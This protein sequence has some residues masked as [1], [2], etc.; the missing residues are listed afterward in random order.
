MTATKAPSKH[1]R[2]GITLIEAVQQYGDDE[3]AEQWLVCRRWPDG[4]RCPDCD[5]KNVAK[6]APRA[7]RRTPEYHCN[8]CKLDFTVKTGTVMH[9]S[10]LSLN[11]WAIAFFLFSTNLKG[12]SSMKLHRD[13]G[14]TQK[15]AWHL[16]HRIR[17]TWNEKTERM[18]GPVEA[19]ETYI[20]G[21]E[22]NKHEA[23]K[24]KAGQGVVGKTPVVGLL[25]RA[26][27]TVKAQKVEDTSAKTIQGFV[28]MNTE[29]NATV[30]TDEAR[31]YEGLNRKH[32]TVK[33]SAGE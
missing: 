17:A 33:H 30:Y 29:F 12:V 11:K 10:K 25:D 27:N 22:K 26:T 2:K 18:A 21:L 32:E 16:A 5:S 8:D 31:A 14:I 13:L 9:D 1:Y 6:R 28:H 24:L 7:K 19:D 23:T 4:M 15:S 20:G 3:K